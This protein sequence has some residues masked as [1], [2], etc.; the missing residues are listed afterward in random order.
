MP[1][2]I[3]KIIRSRP[4]LIKV[5]LLTFVIILIALIIPR[6][7]S[8]YR[9][10]KNHGVS[11]RSI[12]SLNQNP[13][14]ILHSTGNRTNFLLLGIR[15]KEQ[16]ESPYLADTILLISYSYTNK[17]TTMISVPRDLWVNSLK[18]KINAVYYY[19]YQ[20]DGASGGFKL[21]SSAIQE[22]LGLPVHYIIVVDFNLFT[23]TIDNLGGIKVN[24][25]NGFVDHKFPL[26][27]QENAFPLEDRYET[28]EFKQGQQTMGGDLALKFV[29]SRNAEGDEGTDFAR[30]SRQQIVIEAIRNKLLVTGILF[31]SDK[32]NDLIRTVSQNLITSIDP[33]LYP[34]LIKLALN[35]RNQPINHISLN[36]ADK[37]SLSILE[38]PPQANYNGQW[39]LIARDNNWP[40][41]HQY[42][43]NK[44]KGVQ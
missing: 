43:D 7:F 30:A 11:L 26:L 41:L 19:G 14:D 28:V 33:S 38:T 37:T 6:A 20:K 9:L 2:K 13:Q 44:L 32:I 27:G 34:A 23:Q 42:I 21:I 36:Q 22:T 24:V 18:T 8:F 29:R 4:W 31:D 35:I 39:V 10:L 25:Q 5:I 16:L 17:D 12:D 3:K 1:Q 40:A 15:G